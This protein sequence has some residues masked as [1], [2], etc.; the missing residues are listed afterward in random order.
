MV[1]ASAAKQSM[2]LRN[3]QNMVALS[4]KTGLLRHFVPRKDGPGLMTGGKIPPL[5]L[6]GIF[7]IAKPKDVVLSGQ[8]CRVGRALAKPAISMLFRWVTLR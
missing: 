6:G 5:R 7:G 4:F 2:S 1:I 3:M 8:R